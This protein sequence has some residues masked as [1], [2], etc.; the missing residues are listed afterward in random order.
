MSDKTPEAKRQSS[1]PDVAALQKEAQERVEQ[2]KAQGVY[3]PAELKRVEEAALKFIKPE[4]DGY[5]AELN[6]RLES[7]QELWNPKL[8]AVQTHRQGAA[9]KAIVGFK[10]LVHKASSFFLGIW[11]E[12]QLKFNDQLVKLL[13]EY[14]PRHFDLR[15]RMN[16]NETRLDDLEDLGRDLTMMQ[17]ENMRRVNQLEAELE[18]LS[19]KTGQGWSQLESLMARLQNIVEEQAKAGVVSRD[20]VEAVRSE[21]EKSRGTAYVAFEDLHRGSR[22]EIKERQQV[23]VP[24]FRDTASADTPVLDIGCGRGEFLELC[25][26]NDMPARG[27]DL[28][29]EMAKYCRELGLEVAAGDAL[30]YLRGLEDNSL[31]GI[32]A[33]Q[34]IEHLSLDQLTELVSLAAAKLAPGAAF[35]AE[36]VNPQCLTTFSGAFYLDMTHQKPIHPEAARFLWKWAGLE[37]VE[38]LE[39][40]PYPPEHLLEL[41][42]GAIDDP[43]SLAAGYNRNMDRLNQLLYGYQ[44]YAVVGRG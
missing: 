42:A 31:G 40:S 18:V 2:K 21:R 19:R 33:A 30:E 34:V 26:E 41:F 12:R 16:H 15:H 8:C 13:L 44:D 43:Q 6:L 4:E 36:T 17:A 14:M 32:L 28:N 20:T 35:A 3:D 22:E 11:F 5:Q 23:Y 38:I 7:L 27:I 24:V 37:Q 25:R 39:L 10:R 29:P 1:L 9:G